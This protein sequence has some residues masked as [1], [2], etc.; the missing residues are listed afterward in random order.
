VIYKEGK[1]VSDLIMRFF[2]FTFSFLSYKNKGSIWHEG[3]WLW[4]WY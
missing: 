3:E 4:C 2:H 1:N